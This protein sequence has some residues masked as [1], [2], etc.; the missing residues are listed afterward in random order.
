[1][2]KKGVAYVLTCCF[3][4]VFG[5]ILLIFHPIQWVSRNVFG[6]EVHRKVVDCMN[7][8][9]LSSMYILGSRPRLILKSP[10]PERQPIIIVSNHQSMFDIPLISWFL[11]KLYP[12]FISKI[13]L[14][15]G[16]P[17]ISYNLRHGGSV[18]IDRKNPRQSL[19]AIANFAKEVGTNAWGA[20]IFPEGTRGKQGQVKE[21]APA[22]FKILYKNIPDAL[23]L[24][25]TITNNWKLHKDGHFP[26]RIGIPI[27]LTVHK[28][29]PVASQNPEQLL[30]VIRNQISTETI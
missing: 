29:I 11:R 4:F 21:F 12:K 8:C 16:I 30:E 5:G 23:I 1:M 2:I 3:Y 19:P 25:V 24:P 26:L 13:E 27:S 10:L 15:S 20:V 6:K 18:C 7:G 17:S 28:A 22:G 9:L 14:G